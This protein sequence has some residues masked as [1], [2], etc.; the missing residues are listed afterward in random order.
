METV[1]AFV[2]VGPDQ[3]ELAADQL[4]DSPSAAAAIILGRSANKNRFPPYLRPTIH[5]LI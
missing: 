4:L 5:L 1:G 2:V 3:L